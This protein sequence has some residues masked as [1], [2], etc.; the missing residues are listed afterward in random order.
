[1]NNKKRAPIPGSISEDSN[2]FVLE[3][4]SPQASSSQDDKTDVIDSG[5]DP[6][7]SSS[8]GATQVVFGRPQPPV[9][10]KGGPG[11]QSISSEI[12]LRQAEHLKIAQKRVQEL[13]MELDKMQRQNEELLSAAETLKAAKEDLERGFEKLKLDLINAKE[14]SKAELQILRDTMAHKDQQIKELSAQKQELQERLD[15]SFKQVRK[16]EREL[17][18]RLEILKLDGQAVL[19]SKDEALLELKEKVDSLEFE[20]EKLGKRNYTL[21]Q[22][23]Q[24]QEAVLRRVTRALRLA[25]VQLEGESGEGGDETPVPLKKA[26]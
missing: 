26:K 19:R 20:K 13:E 6:A 24:E 14:T 7:S 9:E 5:G 8:K 1:M 3:I 17:E 23:L 12:T 11:Y 25:L 22:E 2:E 21:H 16:R 18:H 10:K 15:Q 4:E